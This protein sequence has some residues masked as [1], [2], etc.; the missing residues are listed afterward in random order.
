MTIIQGTVKTHAGQ[1]LPDAQ[2]RGGSVAADELTA[3]GR[4]LPT[5]AIRYQAEGDRAGPMS[6]H[7]PPTSG[8]A[9]AHG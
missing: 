6:E 1:F 5:D 9:H 2:A 3:G 8:R 4:P 7:M